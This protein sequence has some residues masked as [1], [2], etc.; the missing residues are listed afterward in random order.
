MTN[1][2]KPTEEE[3]QKGIDDALKDDDGGKKEEP[4]TEPP[5]TPPVDDPKEP[6]PKKE[7]P[8]EVKPEEDPEEPESDPDPESPKEP[9]YKK[10]FTD[11][12][13]EARVL[14]SKNKKLTQSIEDADNLEVT[15]KELRGEYADWE[16]LSDFQQKI[17]S[18]TLLNKKKF[19]MVRNA[20]A[21]FKDIDAW[22]AKVDE[23]VGDPRTLIKYSD[24]EGQEEEFKFFAIK[25]SRRGNDFEDL[26]SA[27]LYENKPVKKTGKMMESG[28]G[29]PRKKPSDKISIEESTKLRDS[30]YPE[31]VRLLRAGKI[32]TDI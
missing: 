1:H 4:P 30:N 29:G 7:E 9:D 18:E 22:G 5:A 24:L 12:A 28:S 17:A 31:Y 6:E 11:S 2:V 16:S 15:E 19:E 26:V 21:T 10:R 27:F 32:S 25:K 20:T 14:H 23:F 8:P 13:R 3:L